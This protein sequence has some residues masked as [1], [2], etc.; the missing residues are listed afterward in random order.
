MNSKQIVGGISV[1]VL[2]VILAYPT[3]TTGTIAVS[4]KSSVKVTADHVYV[5]V[6][7]VWAHQNGQ[8][9]S[10]GWKLL[11]NISR[12]VDLVSLQNAPLLKSGQMPVGSYDSIRADFANMTLT[13]HGAS[14]TMQLDSG[15]LSSNVDFRVQ[16]GKSLP[17]IMTIGGQPL[18]GQKIFSMT[19]N[20]VPSTALS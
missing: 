17:L 14:T 11:T 16:A 6:K 10:Q 18:Q 2:L 4:V 15:R 7:D 12:T 1:A 19:L 8:S 20:V 9:Q 13:Y 5:T 3:L